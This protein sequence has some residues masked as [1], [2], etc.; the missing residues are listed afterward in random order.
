MV[1]AIGSLFVSSVVSVVEAVVVV[2]TVSARAVTVASVVTPDSDITASCV[3][4]WPAVSGIL[5]V[6][7]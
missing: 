4:G 2:E 3:A 5:F 6:T 1:R 7:P